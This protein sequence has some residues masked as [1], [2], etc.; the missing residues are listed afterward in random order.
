MKTIMIHEM[1]DH[2]AK[3]SELVHGLP[4][5]VQAVKLHFLQ[6]RDGSGFVQGVVV[7]EVVGEEIFA[8]AKAITQETFNVYYS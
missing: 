6:L 7:K 1:P 3:Q 4:I 5:N 2:V 8:K